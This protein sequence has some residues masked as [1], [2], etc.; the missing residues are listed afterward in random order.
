M[1]E[2]RKWEVGLRKWE[3][4]FLKYNPYNE[5]NKID[6]LKVKFNNKTITREEY[7]ELKKKEK[8]FNNFSK[9]L[10]VYEFKN[11]LVDR[12]KEVVGEISKYEKFEKAKQVVL[13]LDK[14]MQEIQNKIEN[15]KVILKDKNLKPEQRNKAEVSYAKLLDA[16]DKNNERFHDANKIV[17]DGKDLKMENLEKLKEEKQ[18]LN[19]KIGMCHL[20]GKNLMNGYSWDS[21]KAVSAEK[22]KRFTTTEKL[23]K[24]QSKTKETSAKQNDEFPMEEVSKKF[25]DDADKIID[26]ENKSIFKRVSDGIKNRLN[27]KENEK[28]EKEE[29]SLKKQT[30]IEKTFPTFTKMFRNLKAKFSYTDPN[31]SNEVE[32]EK[33]ENNEIKN[34]KTENTKR[35]EFMD[36]LQRVAEKGI[37]EVEKDDNDEKMKNA[38]DRLNQRKKEAYERETKKFG[39]EYADKSYKDQGR[40][41]GE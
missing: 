40:E 12:R 26:S 38:R 10:N 9:V 4:E 11:N 27:K 5:K 18:E 21:I 39:K 41:P 7:D 35:E 31:K 2:K 3:V 24:K 28:E 1:G 29:T 16:Q 6:Q 36:Y 8:V 34:N 15:V 14:E 17:I 22:G 33:E 23:S 20:A 13:K 25:I 37:Y 19:S 30:F 32:I